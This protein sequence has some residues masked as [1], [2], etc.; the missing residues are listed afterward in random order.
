MNANTPTMQSTTAT[1]PANFNQSRISDWSR[2]DGSCAGEVAASPS[3]TGLADSRV[4][5]F[6]QNVFSLG[7]S[8]PHSRQI[9]MPGNSMPDDV[10]MQLPAGLGP[11]ERRR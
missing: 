6:V 5:Q 8:A 1:I 7:S 11:R 2:L 3:T 4:P 9:A 10:G